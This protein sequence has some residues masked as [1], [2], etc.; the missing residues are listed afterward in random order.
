MSHSDHVSVLGTSQLI[1]QTAHLNV[2][3]FKPEIRTNLVKGEPGT[4]KTL[5]G[6][7]LLRRCGRRAY[8]SSRVSQEVIFDKYPE[9]K[10]LFRREESG[11]KSPRQ[12]V[13][14]SRTFGLQTPTMLE[15]ILGVISKSK[16]PPVIL[17]VVE[18]IIIREVNSAFRLV[19]K[20]EGFEEVVA[21]ARR[22]DQ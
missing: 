5:L 22:V 13:Q 7:E 11:R 19:D 20:A 8:L 12:L 2:E 1:S 4:G 17:S 16:E 3:S 6:L 21:R 14:S 18:R 9:L 10:T 15:S